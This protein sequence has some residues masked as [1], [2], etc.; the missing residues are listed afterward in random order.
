MKPAF[1]GL[2]PPAARLLAENSV[3]RA[4]MIARLAAAR[5]ELGP[6]WAPAVPL[7][8][9]PSTNVAPKFLR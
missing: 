9:T 6:P 1:P 7:Y 3:P 4:A 2:L 5:F 8:L